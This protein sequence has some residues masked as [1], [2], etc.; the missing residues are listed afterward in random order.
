QTV[1]YQQVR[2]WT[3]YWKNSA[4]GR[5]VDLPGAG[6]CIG[7]IPYVYCY[8]SFGAP[9]WLVNTNYKGTWDAGWV[10]ITI[11]E[12]GSCA[13]GMYHHHSEEVICNFPENPGTV[14]LTGGV[15]QSPTENLTQGQCPAGFAPDSTGY[16]CCQ[17]P[18]QC[19]AN[20]TPHAYPHCVN[21]D[22]EI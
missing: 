3:V 17:M 5:D 16:Y 2:H 21:C 9:Q 1:M 18:G 22:A 10:N 7:N 4:A 15:C 12:N 6:V 20:P 14:A 11:T 8:P 19:V 13:A